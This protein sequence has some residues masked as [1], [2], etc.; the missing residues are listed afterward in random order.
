MGAQSE[1]GGLQRQWLKG[2]RLRNGG[3]G[4]RFDVAMPGLLGRSLALAQQPELVI[5]DER[6]LMYRYGVRM[7][8]LL[9]SG[10][11]RLTQLRL[12]TSRIQIL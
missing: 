11:V 7:Y 8:V 5:W 4:K 1:E 10:L 2:G 12:Y 3:G 9:R 6:K